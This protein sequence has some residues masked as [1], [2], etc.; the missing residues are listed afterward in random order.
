[1]VCGVSELVC[2]VRFSRKGD[3]YWN[4]DVIS[5]LNGA[6]IELRIA[7]SVALSIP[8]AVFC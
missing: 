1:M 4:S 2:L 5:S 3:L 8:G 7:A 6:A